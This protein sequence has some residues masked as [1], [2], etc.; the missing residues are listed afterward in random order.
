MHD[1]VKTVLFF[2]MNMG[3][4]EWCPHCDNLLFESGDLFDVT[5]RMTFYSSVTKVKSAVSSKSRQE[6]E[7]EVDMDKIGQKFLKNTDVSYDTSKRSLVCDDC[8]GE[9]HVRHDEKLI[10]DSVFE[11]DV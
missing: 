9:L 2:G 8:G 7:E 10:T 11:Q 6:L 1:S 4:D 5:L 3:M